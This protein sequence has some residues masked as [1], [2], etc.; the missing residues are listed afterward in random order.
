MSNQIHFEHPLNERIRALLRLEQLFLAADHAIAGDSPWDARFAFQTLFDLLDVAGRN[1]LRQELG[2]ELDRQGSALE[3]MRGMPGLDPRALDGILSE[4]KS[5]ETAL[6]AS[7]SVPGQDLKDNEF[8]VAIKQRQAVPGGTC[9]FDLPELHQWL[10]L[11]FAQ[12]RADFD[13]WFGEFAGIR[14]VTECLLRLIRGSSDSQQKRAEGGFFQMELDSAKPF[15]MVR[16]SLPESSEFYPEISG[17]K[18]RITIRFM[19]NAGRGHRASQ[20][21]D[22]LPFGLACSLL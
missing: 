11:P 17:G 5:A 12:R 21:T 9:A 3:A 14:D 1:E 2:K 22:D 7:F 15:Q 20:I 6:N 13:Q 8:L 16:V 18:H 10:H 4:L 19:A